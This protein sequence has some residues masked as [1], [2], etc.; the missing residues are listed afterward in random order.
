[1]VATTTTTTRRFLLFNSLLLLLL[2]LL[3]TTTTTFA[4]RLH[5][6]EAEAEAEEIVE[7]SELDQD[8]ETADEQPQSSSSSQ[9]EGGG[10]LIRFDVGMLDGED[11][12]TTGSFVVRTRPDWAPIGVERF[13]ELATVNFWEGCR[14]FRVLP[15]FVSQFGINGD[16]SVQSRWM[17]NLEDDEV[18][19]S[20]VRG[21][22]TFA[23]AGPGT[24]TTQIFINTADNEFLDGMGFSP[25]GEVVSGMD[26]VDRF[27]SG[28]GEGAPSGNGPAQYKIQSEGNSYLE[29]DFP[30]LSYFLTSS[31]V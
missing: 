8:I 5:E 13:E 9:E 23:T 27:Y 28:Y 15:N 31:F 26:I 11:L 12:P 22:V 2:L 20:N 4:R 17:K 3:T 30:L 29:K 21:T 14:I 6:S 16:P 7:G 25:I 18:K 10:K 1:M 19:T 24:R